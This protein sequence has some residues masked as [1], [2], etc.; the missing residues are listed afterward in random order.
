MR[1]YFLSIFVLMIDQIVGLL[2]LITMLFRITSIA[3]LDSLC[4]LDVLDLHGNQV[5]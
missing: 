2:K 5:F 3:N 1:K 4:K